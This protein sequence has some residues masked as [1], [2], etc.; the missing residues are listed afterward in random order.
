MSAHWNLLIT[1][2][3][4]A[5]ITPIQQVKRRPGD[6]LQEGMLFLPPVLFTSV[7]LECKIM[8]GTQQAHHVYLLNKWRN[9]LLAN[10]TEGAGLGCEPWLSAPASALPHG[11]EQTTLPDMWKV[12]STAHSSICTLW[13]SALAML[14]CTQ[15]SE[16]SLSRS[17]CHKWLDKGTGKNVPFPLTCDTPCGLT[18]FLKC[19][20]HTTLW[21]TKSF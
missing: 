19:G 10:V 11:T 15:S 20:K 5:I 3:G 21:C 13:S 14:L 7:S 8:A 17:Q 16:Q 18:Q 12:C 9:A 2:E 1:T 6:K 4:K